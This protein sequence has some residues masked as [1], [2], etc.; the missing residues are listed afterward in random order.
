[1]REMNIK[2]R[3][4]ELMRFG[5]VGGVSFVIDFGF[6]ILFQELV[7]KHVPNGVLISAALS[8]TISL[9]IH[10]FLASFWV[11]RNHDVDN[12][13]SHALAG[14]LFVV[15]NVVGLGLNELAIWVGV[16]LFAYHYV[17]VKLLATGVVM[18]W[19]Y[20]CQK[21]FI[22]KEGACGDLRD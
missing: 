15:T 13:K 9:I 6:L 8:F 5:V 4:L 22:F 14:L 11:F 21:V 12:A 18:M 7:F 17:V 16:S 10:Y 19:N 20:T 1:M 3:L 2:S